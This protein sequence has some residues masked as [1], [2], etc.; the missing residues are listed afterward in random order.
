ML[1]EKNRQ[2]K[3]HNQEVRQFAFAASHDLKEPV[4]TI[5]S[6]ASLLQRRHKEELSESAQEY[7][8]F[9][10]DGAGRMQ[11][12]LDDMLTYGKIGRS[13]AEKEWCDTSELVDM[14]LNNLHQNIEENQANVRSI[15]PTF[16]NLR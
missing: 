2:I 7:L 5:G 3:I 12:L 16:Q 1:A 10:T 9:I 13:N 14:A 11:Q 4:R 15:I 6:F 8:A